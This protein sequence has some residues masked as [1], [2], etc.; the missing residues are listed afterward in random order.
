MTETF[1]REKY[2]DKVRALLAKAEE[3]EE[4]LL[5]QKLWDKP[6]SHRGRLTLPR[7]GGVNLTGLSHGAINIIGMSEGTGLG[8]ILTL[9]EAGSSH[10]VGR[11]M[12][13]GY[14]GAATFTVLIQPTE[15]PRTFRYIQLTQPVEVKSSEAIRNIKHWHYVER[16]ETP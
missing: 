11:G 13:R 15:T 10:W 3:L 8:V 2:V 4:A 6:M 9:H 7:L 12:E 14:S 5:F 1:S 16:L